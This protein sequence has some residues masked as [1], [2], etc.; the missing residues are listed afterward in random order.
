M[1][2]LWN[3]IIKAVIITRYD[4]QPAARHFK[5]KLERRGIQI[6]THKAIKGYPLDIDAL[7]NDSSPVIAL[8]RPESSNPPNQSK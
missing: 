7:R 3:S 8:A 6:Y 5:T 2:L 1:C 4:E